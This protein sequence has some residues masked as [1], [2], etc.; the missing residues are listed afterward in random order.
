MGSRETEEMM[1]CKR[2]TSKFAAAPA[3]PPSHACVYRRLWAAENQVRRE[4]VRGRPDPD[5][6]LLASHR[7]PH[8]TGNP[9]PD[10][11]PE[12]AKVQADGSGRTVPR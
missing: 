9:R 1:A 2:T 3:Q 12:G 10:G 5:A 8:R 6:G 11:Q 4:H 7:Q